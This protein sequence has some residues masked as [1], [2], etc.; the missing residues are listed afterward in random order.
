M[1]PPPEACK[2]QELASA[3]GVVGCEAVG[4]IELLAKDALRG[5][6]NGCVMSFNQDER[7]AGF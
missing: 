7:R 4:D 5:A 1:P 3:D 2:A 6:T